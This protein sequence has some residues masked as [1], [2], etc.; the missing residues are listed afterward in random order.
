MHRFDSTI[1]LARA[2]A[3]VRSGA[4]VT[5]TVSRCCA[6]SPSAATARASSVQISASAVRNERPSGLAVDVIGVFS[7]I[8]L[9][10]AMTA[11]LVDVSR[12]T[13][14][15]LKVSSTTLRKIALN[16]SRDTAASVRTKPSTVAMLGWIIPE[17]LAIPRILTRSP[18]RKI[19]REASL[20]QVSV[21]RMA[22]AAGVGS[23]P[24]LATSDGTAV[25][26]FATGR[27]TPMTPVEHV[28]TASAGTPS[29]SATAPA[30][31]AFARTPDSPVRQLA[32][33]LFAMIARAPSLGSR[34]SLH[35]TAAARVLDW[36]K[37][38]APTAG[39]S[40]R[41]NATSGRFTLMPAAAP[42]NEKPVGSFTR[43]S[44]RRAS[45]AWRRRSGWLATR[46]L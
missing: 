21:V 19:S 37:Q 12:S 38:P 5:R 32:L 44:A 13:L 1:D 28:S 16:A 31:V 10:S 7:A 43:A 2:R 46:R 27:S 14:V 42:A 20:R 9:A 22:D 25:T 26:I 24:R 45:R 34:C 3:A 4:F 41:I 29:A 17:P 6:P 40:D 35:S 11:S 8:P 39:T 33:P 30:M 18:P 23:G 15:M 36:V